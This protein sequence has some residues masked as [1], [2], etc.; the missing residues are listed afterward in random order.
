MNAIPFWFSM[1]LN[2]GALQG[3]GSHDSPCCQLF[4]PTS[5]GILCDSHAV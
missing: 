2:A 1:I 3:W 5:G 4:S